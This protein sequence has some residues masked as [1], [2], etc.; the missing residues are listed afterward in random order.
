VRSECTYDTPTYMRLLAIYPYGEESLTPARIPS[1]PESSGFS[2][3]VPLRSN[4]TDISFKNCALP[5]ECGG[6]AGGQPELRSAFSEQRQL[7]FIDDI[8]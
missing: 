7:I 2:S 1:K 3:R 4:L 5:K 6:N 8:A